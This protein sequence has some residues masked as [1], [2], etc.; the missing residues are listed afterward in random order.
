MLLKL[1]GLQF[2]SIQSY[3]NS[4]RYVGTFLYLTQL[5][6]VLNIIKQ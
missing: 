2:G 1:A 6:N 4:H 5:E 3:I